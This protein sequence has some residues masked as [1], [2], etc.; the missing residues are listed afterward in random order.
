M[1]RNKYYPNHYIHTVRK[2]NCVKIK[3]INDK[4]ITSNNLI[5]LLDNL[6]YSND[7]M[8]IHNY[9]KSIQDIMNNYYDEKF[10]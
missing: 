7:K 1:K 6:E 4:Y 10:N 2:R 3:E 9:M 8:L 5:D